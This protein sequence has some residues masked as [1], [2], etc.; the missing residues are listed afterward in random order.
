M[1]GLPIVGNAK[2][3]M[4]EQQGSGETKELQACQLCADDCVSHIQTDQRRYARI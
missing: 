3:R 4:K 1:A 2:T